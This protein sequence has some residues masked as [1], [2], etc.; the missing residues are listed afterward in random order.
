[1]DSPT[2]KNNTEIGYSPKWKYGK[3]TLQ[4]WSR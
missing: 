4:V 3:R 1:M 2:W